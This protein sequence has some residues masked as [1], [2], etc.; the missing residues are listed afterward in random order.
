MYKRTCNVLLILI[1]IAGLLLS[2]SFILIVEKITALK[3]LLF[4]KQFL[5]FG[6]LFIIILPMV[7]IY[8][9]NLYFYITSKK[10][11]F[12]W[13]KISETFDDVFTV[14]AIFPSIFLIFELAIFLGYYGIVTRL[15]KIL[16]YIILGIVFGLIYSFTQINIRKIFKNGI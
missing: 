9:S 7:L 16:L 5:I 14:V 3:E 2:F 4:F 6:I 10:N 13:L 15:N 12:S 11:W 8:I 1:S